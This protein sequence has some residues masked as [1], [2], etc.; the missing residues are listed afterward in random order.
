MSYIHSIA[1]FVSTGNRTKSSRRNLGEKRLSSPKYFSLR[2][3]ELSLL[4][5]FKRRLFVTKTTYRNVFEQII[6]CLDNWYTLYGHWIFTAI[7]VGFSGC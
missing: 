3:I 1:T 6:S 5:M 2:L 7:I 4:N